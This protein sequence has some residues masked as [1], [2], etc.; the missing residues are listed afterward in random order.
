MAQIERIQERGG[1]GHGH[2]TIDAPAT[3]LPTLKR[4]DRRL[5]IHPVRGQCEGLRGPTAGIQRGP[6]RGADLAGGGF[7][8]AAE[9]RTLGSGER[10]GGRGDRRSACQWGRA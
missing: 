7:G 10:A 8:G 9:R 5:D 1:H 3:F 4:E 6:A 2:G